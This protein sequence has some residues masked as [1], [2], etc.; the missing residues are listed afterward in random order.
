MHGILLISLSIRQWILLAEKSFSHTVYVLFIVW[1]CDTGALIGGRVG[2]MLFKSNDILGEQITKLK[3]GQ[4]FMEILHSIS[5]SKSI[6]GFLGGI[7]FGTLTAVYLPEFSILVEQYLK[8]MSFTKRINIEILTNDAN[9]DFSEQR[10]MIGIFLSFA[11]IIGDL[12][13]SA[14]KRKSGHKD[15]ANYIPGHGGLLDRFDS[16][17]L[18][19]GIYL[20][21]ANIDVYECNI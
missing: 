13:E 9:F 21:I 1:N 12:V 19:V 5:S 16:T 2:K 7:I 17:F 6:T 14:V 18:A 3:V 20:C 11:G 10:M 8:D 4:H 15:S